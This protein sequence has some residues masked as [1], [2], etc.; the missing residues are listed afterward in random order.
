[1]SDATSVDAYLARVQELRPV[2]RAHAERSE[3]EAQLAPEVVEAF[4]AAGLFRI[5]FPAAMNGGDLG[6][7]E[8]YRVYEE[9]AR[10]DGSAGWNLSICAGGPLF[11]H[12]LAR[13]AFDEIFRDPRAL[14]AGSLNPV[15]TQAVR[16]GDR[17]KFSGRAS[18]VSGSAQASWLMS[19]GIVVVDGVP[20]FVDGIPVMRAGVFPIRHARILSTWDVAGMRG[21]GSNDCV[22]EDVLVPDGFTFE[23]P[24]GRSAWREGP[25]A[26]IPPL[27]QVGG[28]LAAVALG[29]ARHAIDEL[30][31]I[32]GAKVPAGTRASLRERP[33]AQLQLGEA[34]GLLQAGRAYLYRSVEDVWR[35]GAERRPFDVH[36][37]AAA[38]LAS[39]TAV[40]L[41]AQA[42]DLVH[43]AAGMSAVKTSGDI[44]RCWRDVH[45]ITQHVILATARY[46]VVGRVLFGLPPGSPII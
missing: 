17:W 45:T 8:A 5:F 6:L 29:V 22:F 7:P 27:L 41:A 39:V 15:G 21:T 26:D 20:Q 34:E 37:R 23:W 16:D 36:A 33:L 46:E 4:H 32:A 9:V 2:V 11:G 12:F 18:Y 24:E 19:A 13:A 38:R 25:F 44:Q 43:D 30:I 14:I 1:M 3:R 42:V 40:K 10:L 31:E 35:R 28:T